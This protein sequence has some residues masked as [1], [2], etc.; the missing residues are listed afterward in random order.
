[1]TPPTERIVVRRKVFDRQSVFFLGVHLVLA[2][3][4]VAVV[5]SGRRPAEAPGPMRELGG[6]LRGAGLPSEALW[7]YE[8]AALDLQLGGVERAK[9]ALAAGDLAE[10]LGRTEEALRFW[11]LVEVLDPHSPDKADVGTRVVRG[12]ERLGKT[13]AADQALAAR[14]ARTG[15]LQQGGEVVAKIGG[16]EITM[17]DV[18][19]A[20]EGLPPE[21]RA[22]AEK[23]GERKRLVQQYV[24]EEVLY[25]KA[26]KLELDKDP[27]VR[28]QLDLVGRKLVVQRLVE[29]EVASKL[30]V[31][32]KDVETFWKANQARFGGKP[33]SEV[34]GE[35]ERA[36]RGEKIQAG[37]QH[38][39]EDA[40]RQSDVVV[41]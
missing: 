13:A 2:G 18:D 31:D 4:I 19:K 32:P 21:M 38:M 3:A 5:L 10:Q 41:K 11:H 6:R 17:A 20:L 14:T 35:V 30:T 7:A 34:K 15:T 36:Y 27:T 33:F 25:R 22:Q 26:R 29:R 8:R 24:A 1:M 16:D 28:Q 37:A 12:L 9:L 40:L 23:R 39:L